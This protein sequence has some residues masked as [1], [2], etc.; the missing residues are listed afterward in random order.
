M[1]SHP[2]STPI[3]D[4]FSL[5]GLEPKFALD[6]NELTRAYRT[7][8]SHVHPD[9][10]AAA[11]AA[12]QRAALQWATLAN[13]AYQVLSSPVRRAAYLCERHGVAVAGD[14]G[15]AV[16]IDFLDLQLEWRQALEAMRR[17]PDA[18]RL[19]Q[20]RGEAQE[21][22]RRELANLEFRLDAQGDYEGAAEGVRRLMFIEKFLLELRS[23]GESRHADEASPAR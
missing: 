1:A 19:E 8:Q 2:V 17:N 14:F 16:S 20:L 18:R 11:G 9:R 13:E 4:H 15:K 5:F 12:E 6:P 22:S 10:Y 3:P 7:V 23:A 21:F